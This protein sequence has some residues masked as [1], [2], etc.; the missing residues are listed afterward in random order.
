MLSAHPR[1]DCGPESR[2]FARYRHLDGAAR[3]RLVDAAAWPGPAIEFLAS[4]QNQGHPVIDLFG[5]TESEVRS[6]LG[7]RPP[8]LATILEALTVLHAEHAGKPRWLEKTPRHLLMTDTLRR[9]WPD[10]RI[11]RIVRDPRDTALSL[12]AM[13]FAKESVV[14][15]LVRI[16]QDDRASRD[17]IEADP[18]A[19]TLRY[20]DLVSEPA[21]ELARVCGFIGETY[22]PSM[23]EGRSSAAEGVAAA[24][25]WWKESVAGP[26]TTGSVGRWRRDMAADVQRFAEL[27]LAGFLRQHGYEGA[28][29]PAGEIA[30]VPVADGVGPA[31]ES[32]LLELARRDTVVERPAPARSGELHRQPVI[33][34][35]GVRGQLD[36][37]RDLPPASRAIGAV[38]L[39]AGLLVRRLQRR[40]MLWVR[41]ATLRE[42]RSRDPVEVVVVAGLRALARQVSL[43]AVGQGRAPGT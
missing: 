42:R 15:N 22:E 12:S 32:L 39:V 21:R 43:E 4:L 20:E 18:L 11:L 37:G 14:G 5:L 30:V 34:F 23:L 38:M 19:M 31:N 7:A 3:R 10:A 8:A 25:E 16:D 27:H 13:P 17:R 33:V 41:N 9:L 35:L 6:W 1:L 24:H 28:R 36:P 29:D 26:L 2:F 40:P